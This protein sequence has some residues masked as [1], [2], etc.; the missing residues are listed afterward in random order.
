MIVHC[1]YMNKT[2]VPTVLRALHSVALDEDSL[3]VDPLLVNMLEL[4]VEI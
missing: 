1:S 3:L 4:G 2:V